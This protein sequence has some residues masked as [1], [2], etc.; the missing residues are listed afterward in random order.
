VVVPAAVERF[1]L[2]PQWELEFLCASL[3]AEKV[4]QPTTLLHETFAGHAK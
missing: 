1:T 2:K 4:G 3:P